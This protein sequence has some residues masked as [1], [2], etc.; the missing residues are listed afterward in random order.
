MNLKKPAL[1][2]KGLYDLIWQ[3]PVK[4]IAE[5]YQL[6][7]HEVKNICLKN[8]IPMPKSGH[9]SKIKHGKKV[10]RP[11]L[12]KMKGEGSI[13]LKPKKS[14][15]KFRTEYQKRA[16]ELQQQFEL[17]FIVPKR[18]IKYH[19]LIRQTQKLLERLDGSKKDVRFWDLAREY[20][21]L[22]IHTDSNLRSR[23][24]RFMNTFI[25]IVEAMNGSIVFEYGRYHVQ[26]FG[27]KTEINLRQKYHR[28]RTKDK[29]GWS[30]ESWEKTYKLEFQAGPSFSQKNWIDKKTTSLEE[31]LPQI[32]AWIEK[33]C[34]YWHDLRALQAIE[35]N[36]RA[37]REQKQ[38]MIM[39]TKEQEMAKF[40]TLLVNTERFEKA[41][42][43][44]DYINKIEELDITDN[45]VKEY[46][47]WAR[48]KADWV[49]P[50]TDV[51]DDILGQYEDATN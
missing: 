21:I 41:K 30:T 18:V 26:M 24:F 28:I 44:R 11:S 23:A 33:D 32:I 34:K 50:L 35:S 38:K 20:E 47:K 42:A 9:W 49:D 27:Q 39:E 5:Q 31:Y 19:P 6:K 10:V 22:P 2:R 51:K 1:T 45:K 4:F 43:I 48:L 36:K 25:Q 40:S 17:R 15:R 12:P 14:T 37:L 16:F 29:S 13:L 8:E 7:P 46:L 3:K